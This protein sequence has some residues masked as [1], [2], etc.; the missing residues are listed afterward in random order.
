[1]STD[2]RSVFRIAMCALVPLAAS[3]AVAVTDWDFATAA[4]LSLYRDGN[5]H[6]VGNQNESDDVAQVGMT[7]DLS[8][9]RP[10]TTF[11]LS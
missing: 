6:G 10:P 2:A 7:F 9:N 5:V 4:S 1:M 3:R 11:R 8:G